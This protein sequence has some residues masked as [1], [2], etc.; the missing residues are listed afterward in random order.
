MSNSVG[1]LTKNLQVVSFD[2][3][4]REIYLGTVRRNHFTAFC[5]N[6]VSTAVNIDFKWV[7]EDE[8]PEAAEQSS[9]VSLT[10]AKWCPLEHCTVLVLGSQFGIKLYDWDGSTLIFHYGFVEN[11]IGVDDRQVTG[12]MARGKP[13]KVKIMSSVKQ[14]LSNAGHKLSNFKQLW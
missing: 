4:W 11:G 6:D 5:P 12:A 14:K 7:H 9:I 1:M 8:G 13:I 3:E 10:V 2:S